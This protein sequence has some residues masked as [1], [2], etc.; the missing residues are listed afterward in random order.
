[1]KNKGFTLVETIGVLLIL[2]LIFVLVFPN[3][4]NRF[5]KGNKAINNLNK[6]H[7]QDAFNAFLKDNKIIYPDGDYCINVSELEDGGYLNKNQ[8]KEFVENN[9]KSVNMK[10]EA[11]ESTELKYNETECAV[12]TQK[13]H[14]KLN[15]NEMVFVEYK[16][17]SYVEQGVTVKNIK[18]KDTQT[19]ELIRTIYNSD[20]EQLDEQVI[21]ITSTN[22]T[23]TSY[24]SYTNSIQNTSI[25]N[26]LIKYKL[27]LKDNGIK[28][29]D[30]EVYRKVRVSDT[31]AP[32]ITLESESPFISTE[33][34]TYN[35]N[36]IYTVTDKSTVKT[37]VKTNLTLGVKGKYKTEI[38]AVDENGNKSTKTTYVTILD[39]QPGYY[40]LEGNLLYTWDQLVSNYGLDI[41]TNYSSSSPSTTARSVMLQIKKEGKLVI[42]DTVTKIGSQAF[43]N[44]NYIKI[45]VIPDSVTS[46]GEKAFYASQITSMTIGSGA[47]SISNRAFG[48]TKITSLKI[49]KANPVY[50][51]REDCNCVV[52]TATNKLIATSINSII[53]SDVTSIGQYAYYSS[54]NTSVTIPN[55]ITSIEDYAF[56][57]AQLTEITL[58]D[59]LASI[60]QGVFN[61][62]KL[63]TLHIGKSTI[64]VS[65]HNIGGASLETITVSPE[66]TKYDSRDNCN[67]IVETATNTLILGSVGTTLPSS[68]TTIGTYAYK[69]APITSIVLPSHVTKIMSG[70]FSSSGLETVVIG[71]GLNS[72][73]VDAFQTTNITSFIVDSNNQKYD[74]RDNCNCMI[75]TATNKLIVGTISTVIPNTV[76]TIGDKAFVHS[77]ITSLT[78]PNSV[79]SI[80]SEVFYKANNLTTLTIPSS[81]TQLSTKA[82]SNA[83][84]T[85]V[86]FADPTG[87]KACTAVDCASATNL[88]LTNPTTNA[89]YL[90][91]TYVSKYW[92]KD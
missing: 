80:G 20:G 44:A 32:V 71:S 77:N 83:K 45:L 7:I 40:D 52:E 41:E 24:N 1:M 73:S 43:S 78:I 62:S 33:Y 9:I 12:S 74:S 70:A 48:Y 3:M 72:I 25:T 90:K 54:Y 88:T 53:P 75:T 68:V 29:I 37:T 84:V 2:A 16:T 34:T 85:S 63:K 30:E 89:T 19:L 58:P 51:S 15:G 47:T 5:N 81:V 46:I 92:I 79:T 61:N 66:N 82:F 42:P 59:N 39:M 10:V 64:S 28:I 49:N 8:K 56:Y 55:T 4:T 14:L 67:C 23:S 38:T 57:T 76:T 91:T 18:K 22:I 26:Y 17:D 60:G 50:D 87:W 31:V 13:E 27:V 11:L 86:T 35:I 6:I 36:D 69:Q 21:T 65:G